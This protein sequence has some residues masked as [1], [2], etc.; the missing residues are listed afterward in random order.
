MEK[1]IYLYGIIPAREKDVQPLP[2]F[3]G[4]DDESEVYSLPFEEI[5]AVVCELD[6]VEYGEKELEKK[7]NDVKWLHQKAFHHHEALM[8]L[9]EKYP[10]IPMKFCTIYSGQASLKNTIETNQSHMAKLLSNIADKEEWILKI[11]CE[12]EKVKETVTNYNETIEA[13]KEEIAAMSPGRQYLEKRRLDQLIDQEAEKEKHAFSEEIHD[14]L[15]ALSV[16]TEVKKN[17]NKDVTGREEEMCWNSV[18][19]LEKFAV[20]EFKSVIKKLQEKWAESGWHFE[21]TGPW[22]SYHFARIS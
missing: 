16:D 21:V 15:A 17:W 8:K 22:P 14:E 18:Y 5:E 19:M 13:K 12:P 3:K 2:S 11:Y 4:L 1:L 10:I 9:Y 20:D 6:P 7:T